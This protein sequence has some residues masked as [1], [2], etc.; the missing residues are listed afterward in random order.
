MLAKQHKKEFHLYLRSRNFSCKP[1]KELIFPKR[2][3]YRM[4]S[5]TKTEDITRF[6]VALEIN[7]PEACHI[8]GDKIL[9]KKRLVAGNIKTA[10]WFTVNKNDVNGESVKSHLALWETP[11]IVKHIHSSKGNGIYLINSIED[12]YN[13]E[14]LNNALGTKE[15]EKYVFERYYTYT[16][17]YRIHVNRERCFF[18]TRK[19]LKNEADIRW[20]RHAENAVFIHQDNP[21]FEKPEN[22]DEITG[23]CINALKAIGLDFAAFDVKVSKKGKFIILES[24]SAPALGE[25]SL[26]AYKQELT[27]YIN[28]RL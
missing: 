4:G 13:T 12:L 16:K 10:E 25:K 20:H 6:Q 26:E 5:E 7:S 17:E 11:I 23:E 9:T 8:S 2:V 15:I 18:A 22:W 24:N 1:L 14:D 21:L 19:M 27:R 28:E 3:I